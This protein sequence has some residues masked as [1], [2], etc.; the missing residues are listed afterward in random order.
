MFF[1]KENQILRENKELEM[2]KLLEA[3]KIQ[4]KLN[5]FKQIKNE[6]ENN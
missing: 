4:K 1:M 6:N 5:E 2:N 3:N